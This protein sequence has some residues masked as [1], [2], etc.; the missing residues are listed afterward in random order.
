MDE[1]LEKN[2]KMCLDFQNG[3]YVYYLMTCKIG[4]L[5]EKYVKLTDK[6]FDRIY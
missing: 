3:T 6:E 1:I 2:E 5:I 4:G